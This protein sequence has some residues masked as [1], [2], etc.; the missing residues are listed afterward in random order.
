M[1][2]NRHSASSPAPDADPAKETK[3]LVPGLERGLMIL[4]QFSAREPL[5]TAPELSRRLDI[6]RSTVFRILQTLEAMG[7]VER[8][9][10]ERQYRLGVAVLRL[11]FDYLNS[12]ELTDLGMPVINRMRDLTGHSS[13]IVIRDG[14]HIVFVAKA[15]GHNSA[16]SKVTVGTRLPA[17]ATALGRVLMGD[18]G[19]AEIQAMYPE[20]RLEQYSEYT[21][22]NVAELY[23]RVHADAERGYAVSQAFFESGI[24]VVAAPVRNHTGR[25]V[26]AVSLTIAAPRLDEK[27]LQEKLISAVLAGAAE[28]SAKLN[29]HDHHDAHS[30]RHSY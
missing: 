15:N 28:L 17:H 7:F 13:Q 26:A 3:Y 29:Y 23:Q 11:G 24:S 21:P 2:P 18:L 6:P 12:L 5:L 30:S 9:P 10:D 22:K 27:E 14:R 8:G 1:L 16:F 4:M 20:P 25:I 19:E